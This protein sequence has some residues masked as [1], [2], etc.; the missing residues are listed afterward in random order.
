LNNLIL[1]LPEIILFLFAFVILSLDMV[2]Q[3]D[4]SKQNTLGYLTLAACLLATVAAI[5]VL[6][7]GNLAVIATDAQGQEPMMAADHFAFFFKIYASLTALLV[8]L[9]SED[10]I[11]ARI[12][13]RGEFYALM[14]LAAMSLMLVAGSVN[15][16]MIFLAFEF[17]SIVSYILTG[18]M[19]QDEKS[20]EGA[21]KYFIYGAAASSVM[22]FGFSLLYGAS[23]ALDLNGI[24]QGLATST[25]GTISL[26]I[27]PA[28][29]LVIVGLGF[30]IA[31]VPFHQWAP[32]AYQGAPTPITAFLSVGPKAAG[33]ALMARVLIIGFPAAWNSWVILLTG[34]AILTMTFGNLVALWQRDM[35][36]LFAYSSIA[37]AGYML[38]GVVAIAP[39]IL[40]GA[41]TQTW[42]EGLNGMLYYLLAYLF[43]NLGAFAVIIAV[44]NQT[45][46]T[47][48]S[49]Y[50]GL[51]RRAPF[52]AIAMLVFFLSLVGIPPTAGFVGKFVVLGAAINQ[53]MYFLA[54]VAIINSVISLYYYFFVVRQMFFA[55]GEETTPLSVSMPVMATVAVTTALVLLMAIWAQPFIRW[56][57]DSAQILA[58]SF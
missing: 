54:I 23:G 17:L 29:V 44:E 31:L 16:V 10:Y 26:L 22:L 58:T 40:S 15:L 5:W 35:K 13:F 4:D 8:A 52:L 57:T 27:L 38:I 51:F 39:Q 14:L 50:A 53:E 32:E 7:Q 9:I 55:D 12:R 37:Q 1:L 25:T 34:I 18:Y 43:T 24:A 3:R 46:S 19:R 28:L 48:I 21:V 36:R 47:Q 49:A 33:L 30:K 11:R 6:L 20:I 2:W 45:G 42:N 41:A 56:T